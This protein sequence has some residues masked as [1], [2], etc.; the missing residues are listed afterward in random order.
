MITTT[1]AIILNNILPP[2]SPLAKS[3][4]IKSIDDYG[5]DGDY[6][7]SQAF[8]FLAIR[9]IKKLP[10][11]FPDTTGCEKPISGGEIVEY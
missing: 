2:K 5:V 1:K 9:S 6:V 11:S 3:S 7:E 10:I 4:G 8:A